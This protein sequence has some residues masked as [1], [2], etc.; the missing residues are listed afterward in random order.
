M[1]KISCICCQLFLGGGERGERNNKDTRFTCRRTGRFARNGQ[2]TPFILSKSG[3][4]HQS[5]IPFCLFDV[6]C[7]SYNILHTMQ[8]MFY[9]ASGDISTRHRNVFVIAVKRNEEEKEKGEEENG[10]KK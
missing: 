6:F 4:S 10:K 5:F 7:V 2:K 9:N 8:N 1:L 3:A